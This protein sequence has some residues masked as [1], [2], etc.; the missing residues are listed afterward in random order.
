M[1]SAREF[2]E[3]EIYAPNHLLTKTLKDQAK[4]ETVDEE[5]LNKTKE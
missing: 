3:K 1:Q 2:A 5:K 4:V